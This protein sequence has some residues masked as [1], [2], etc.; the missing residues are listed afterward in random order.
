[1]T[2]ARHSFVFAAGLGDVIR[3]IFLRDSY[4]RLSMTDQPT[5]VVLASHNPFSIEIFPPANIRASS[6]AWIT[7]PFGSVRGKLRAI[8]YTGTG[9]RRRIQVLDSLTVPA[10]LNLVR[11]ASAY[12]G[13]WSALQQAAWFE[14]KPVAVFY[15]VNWGDVTKRT[16]YAFGLDRL[17]CFRSDFP[18][19]NLLAFERWVSRHTALVPSGSSGI[20]PESAGS[21]PLQ[22]GQSGRLP[23]AKP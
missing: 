13:S 6:F 2:P 20:Q 22:P 23:L 21:A 9:R 1:M 14:N 5:A 3:V 16:G 19:L 17:D 7:R 11:N 4:R 18:S 10:S 12:V 8:R 15:P